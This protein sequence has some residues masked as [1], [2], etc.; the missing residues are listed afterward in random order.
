MDVAE[1]RKIVNEVNPP[2]R[3]KPMTLTKELSSEIAAA[4]PFWAPLLKSRDI[5]DTEGGDEYVTGLI[6]T[7][8]RIYM[9][10]KARGV[11]GSLYTLDLDTLYN[12]DAE[13]QKNDLGLPDEYPA[14]EMAAVKE[15]GAFGAGILMAYALFET[16][17]AVNGSSTA[18]KAIQIPQQDPMQSL[19][20]DLTAGLPEVETSEPQVDGSPTPVE[21]DPESEVK[22]A[23]PL[24][25]LTPGGP[26]RPATLGW[27]WGAAQAQTPLAPLMILG[28]YPSENGLV[29][30]GELPPTL[31]GAAQAYNVIKAIFGLDANIHMGTKGLE[32]SFAYVTKGGRS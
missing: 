5:R 8:G 18:P 22:H 14:L 7:F 13:L 15:M 9:A 27:S 24:M 12:L 11:H 10:L 6:E 25:T 23:P 1:M 19:M 2:L 26:T 20:D 28:I 17:L 29:V 30:R 4:V 31:S 21:F 16:A 32:F 3:G